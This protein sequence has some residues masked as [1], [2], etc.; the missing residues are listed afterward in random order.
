MKITSSGHELSGR[1]AAR[2]IDHIIPISVITTIIQRLSVPVQPI[3]QKHGQLSLR[4]L[5]LC[6]WLVDGGG[7]DDCIVH[8][9]LLGWLRLDVLA[10]L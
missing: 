4:L 2:S 7:L 5:D 9:S 8:I 6:L 10:C 1:C 3:P